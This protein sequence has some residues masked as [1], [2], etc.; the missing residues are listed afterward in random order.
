MAHPTLIWQLLV[1][2]VHDTSSTPTLTPAHV[3]AVLR[4]H[5]AVTLALRSTL[6]GKYAPSLCNLIEYEGRQVHPTPNPRTRT[7]EKPK[8]K[9]KTETRTRNRNPNPEPEPNPNPNPNQKPDPKLLRLEP[10]VASH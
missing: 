9:P 10:L 5:D 1:D 2:L 3:A 4:A 8:P 6:D 7:P